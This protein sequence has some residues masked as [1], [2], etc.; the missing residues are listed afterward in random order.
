MTVHDVAARL[1]PHGELGTIVPTTAGY[2]VHTAV[3]IP[4]A[5]AA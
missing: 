4:D 3:S 2:T 1:F 5:S